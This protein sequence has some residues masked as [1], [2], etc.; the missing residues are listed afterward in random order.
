[1]SSLHLHGQGEIAVE[2]YLKLSGL[3]SFDAST[4]VWAIEGSSKELGYLTHNFLRFFGKFPPP[5]AER[6]IRELH[7]PHQGPILD[8]MMGSGTTLVESMRASR[9][10]IG[11]DVNPLFRMV[12]RV[13]TTFIE[14]SM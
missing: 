8:P 6:F 7:L 4:E 5:V 14:E 1:M 2:E 13:K 11:I 10:A 12:A 3:D 9:P